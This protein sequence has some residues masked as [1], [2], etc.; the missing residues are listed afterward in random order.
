MDEHDQGQVAA[1]AAEI[2]DRFFVPALFGQWPGAVLDAAGVRGDDHVLDVACGTGVLTRAA[3]DVVGP[4]GRVVGIDLNEGMLAVARARDARIEW[5]SGVA[6]KL[7]FEA[8]SFDRVVS[9]FG[10]MFFS[11]R[12]AAAAEMVRVLRPG[13]QGAVA[14]WAALENAPGYLKVAAMLRD[15]FDDG[16][17]KSIEVPYVLGDP[18]ALA[19]LF[20]PVAA[21]V[22]VEIRP[23]SARFESLESWLYTDV[24]GWTLADVIDDA[25]FARLQA[26]APD[27]LGEFV[28][29]DGTVEFRHPAL[30]VT[31]EKG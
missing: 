4:G 5:M 26:A 3:R 13:G 25:G 8:A 21:N 10:L 12:A 23:G 14:V 11:D 27:Y 20:E 7:P 9:Q 28:R 31:F 22:N 18:A 1:S 30:I 17:A 19:A 6:E 15:V 2:Y 29:S 16:I 24:R